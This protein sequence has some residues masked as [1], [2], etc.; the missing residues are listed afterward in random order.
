M[1]TYIL[2]RF[3]E[4][5]PVLWAILTLAFFMVAL[6]PGSPFDTEKAMPKEVKAALEAQYGLDDPLWVQYGRYL[7]GAVRGDL[8][9]SYKYPGWS[10]TELILNKIPVSLE[11]GFYALCIALVLGVLAG[12]LAAW[13]PNTWTDYLP[14]S[15]AMV[16]ICLPAFVLG[17]LLILIFALKLGWLNVSGWFL[18]QDRILP[19][20]TLGLVYAATIARLTRG[21]MVEVSNQDYMRTAAAKGLSPWRIHLVH[22]LRNAL[23]PVISYLGPLAA[24]LV[25][26]SFVIETVFNV[27]GLGRFFVDAALNQDSTMV[28]GTVIF[29]ASVLIL[30][31]LMADILLVIINPRQKFE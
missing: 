5:L 14:M 3:L 15:A 8:G 7:W 19:A 16:G 4:T 11:L 22:G 25:T 28:L 29:Y 23:T 13:R 26:G 2:R 10:V 30:M 27:P 18:P 24:A 21:S 17:P 1:L 9:P 6:S 31:N 20:F 12:V